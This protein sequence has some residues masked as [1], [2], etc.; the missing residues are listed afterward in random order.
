MRLLKC[1]PASKSKDKDGQTFPVLQP[2][3]PEKMAGKVFGA[4]LKN[5]F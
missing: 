3:P 4:Q 1:V 2:Q 5:K